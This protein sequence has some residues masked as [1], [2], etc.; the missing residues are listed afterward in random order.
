MR[1]GTLLF[2]VCLAAVGLTRA[3]DTTEMKEHVEVTATKVPE[4][5]AEVP[6]SITVV[7]GQDLRDRGATDLRSA[8]FLVSGVDIAPGSDAGPAG[9]VP[10]LW[11]LKEFDA[12][13]LVLDGVPYGGAFNPA[14]PTLPLSE[15]ERI[16]VVRGPAPVTY[17]A[18]SFVGVIQVVRTSPDATRPEVAAWAGT[19]GSGGVQ[20][21]QPLPPVG[22]LK[23]SFSADLATQGFEDDRTQ[24]DRAHV[25][26]RGVGDFWGGKV[27]LGVDGTWLGQDPASPHPRQGT[28]LSAAV[29]LD[30]NHNPGGAYVND[31]RI[32]LSGG[33]D[34]TAMGGTWSTLLSVSDSAG[35]TLRGFLGEIAAVADNGH[36][37]RQD[38]DLTDVYLDTHL[39]WKPEGAFRFLAGLDYLHG[40]G[41]MAGGDFD[42]TIA[43]DGSNPPEGEAIPSAGVVEIEDMRDFAGLYGSVEWTPFERLRVDVGARLNHT[44]EEREAEAVGEIEEGEEGESKESVTRGSGSL[45]A[46]FTVWSHGTDA[47]RIFADYRNTF[48]PAAIDFGVEA[49][50]G[51][52][53]PETGESYEAGVKT[54]FLDGRLT[55][56]VTGFQMDLDN[57]VVSQVGDG[58]TPVLANAG[59]VRL[60]GAELTTAYAFTP[61]L[62]ANLS[63]ANHDARFR[64]HVTEFDG[65]PTQLEGKK[66]EMSP[67]DLAALGVVWAPPKG[68]RAS[69]QASYVG[70][71]YLNKR[72]T[73][74]ADAF[75][76]WSAGVGYRFQSMEL[77]VDGTNLNEARDP[78][79]ESEL[80]DA[81][82]YRMPSRTV[83]LTAR[84]TR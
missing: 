33:F 32:H 58:G 67:R 9:S 64:D 2:C 10:A 77:R 41:T 40:K 11:G 56:E 35:S 51:I 47:L 42:Y 20:V 49:E 52:L 66:L 65:V 81:Q 8:L 22:K 12:F 36:G 44:K 75:V 74:L 79:A 78:V 4:D 43:L 60:R 13:L 37:L 25:A 19:H 76:T 57:M 48:K 71:R 45:G 69:A 59:E 24:Y 34:A 63:Y 29:P 26:W 39:A 73:A 31:R 15:V 16:E 83:A 1:Q 5:P 61:A 30:A 14:I 23:S 38:I 68:L 62:R 27:T 54:A 53:D 18:T 55:A 3:E 28:S 46:I 50:G 70:E 7:S 6:Q 84:W 21:V 72:N 17:G 80:G 82:Y